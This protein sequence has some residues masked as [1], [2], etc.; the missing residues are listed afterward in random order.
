MA[1]PFKELRKLMYAEGID[2][3]FLA[4]TLGKGTTYVSLRIRGLAPWDMLDVYVL[5]DLFEIP[6]GEIPLYFPRED[7]CARK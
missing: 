3:R 5:C 4:M 1:K 2:Q 6:T 7:I